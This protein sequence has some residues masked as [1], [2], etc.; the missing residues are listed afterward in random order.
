MTA[1]HELWLVKPISPVAAIGV[2]LAGWAGQ[3]RTAGVN[4]PNVSQA[5]PPRGHAGGLMMTAAAEH[6]SAAALPQQRVTSLMPVTPAEVLPV[7]CVR[8]WEGAPGLGC[9]GR[10]GTGALRQPLVHPS[11]SIERN[12]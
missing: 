12:N 1:K 9:P 5:V 10:P 7:L 6:P 3:G 2:P 8:L 4:E 11:G